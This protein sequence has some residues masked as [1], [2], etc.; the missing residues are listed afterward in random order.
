MRLRKDDLEVDE[1][2]SHIG[3][4]DTHSH[5]QCETLKPVGY[6][7]ETLEVLFH[8]NTDILIIN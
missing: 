5:Q 1:G 7:W 6:S 4:G 3:L 2:K 8:M